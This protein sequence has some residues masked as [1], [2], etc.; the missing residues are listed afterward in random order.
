MSL[1]Q[2]AWGSRFNAF[3]TKELLWL[4]SQGWGYDARYAGKRT[5][6][7]LAKVRCPVVHLGPVPLK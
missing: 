6:A 5:G 1:F 3:T 4:A 2:K 7:G